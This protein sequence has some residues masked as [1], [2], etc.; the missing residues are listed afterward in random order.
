VFHAADQSCFLSRKLYALRSKAGLTQKEL[1]ELVGTTASVI[2]RLED[3]NYEGHSLT[4]LRR[5]AAALDTDV[6]VRFTHRASR[7][8]FRATH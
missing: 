7:T 8:A 2:S 6:H 1:A 4:M 3:A 5:V